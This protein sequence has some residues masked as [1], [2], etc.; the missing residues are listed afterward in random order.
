MIIFRQVRT[1]SDQNRYLLEQLRTCQLDLSAA[2]LEKEKLSE[3]LRL[4][5]KLNKQL[6]DN[7]QNLDKEKRSLKHDNRSLQE[8]IL[9]FEKA[10]LST[11]GR[12]TRNSGH[13]RLSLKR[14]KMTDPAEGD[15]HTSTM[16]RDQDINLVQLSFQCFCF[17]FPSLCKLGGTERFSSRAV[18]T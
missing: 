1:A 3:E 11:S 2:N 15:S 7:L 6:E 9:K 12:K 17:V 14:P 10:T 8:K 18:H 4:K 16:V 13:H 5:S